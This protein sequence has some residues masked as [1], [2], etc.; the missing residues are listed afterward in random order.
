M[1]D[2]ETPP[3]PTLP[4][5]ADREVP[6]ALRDWVRR[7]LGADGD[8]DTWTPLAGGHTN[9]LWRVRGPEGDLVL[10]LYVPGM[11]SR[12]FP[13][14][15][16]AEARA[17]VHLAGTGLAPV[18]CAFGR[19]GPGRVL[20]Y[21]AVEGAVPRGTD[22]AAVLARALSD[23]HARPVADRF[24]RVSLQPR[25]LVRGILCDLRGVPRSPDAAM[26]AHIAARATRGTPPRLPQEGPTALLHGDP[27]AGNALVSRGDTVTLIDWQCP[28]LGDPTHDLAIALSPGMRELYGQAPFRPAERAAFW[29]AYGR[30]DVHERLRVLRPL[31]S[32]RIA[33]HF[34]AQAARGRPGYAAAAEAELAALEE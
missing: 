32:A 21:R 23:L 11:A 17:L 33:A 29:R 12:L 26:L 16:E 20:C 31:L 1:K 19:A 10:K 6:R 7:R 22:G 8:P 3:R 25:A 34:L 13:N 5:G 30:W 15:P 14:S 27:A 24:R 18:I 2:S 4:T 9:R 28:A